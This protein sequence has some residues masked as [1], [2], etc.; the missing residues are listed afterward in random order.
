MPDLHTE[1]DDYTGRPITADAWNGLRAFREAG[2]VSFHH[3]PIPEVRERYIAS[4]KANGLHESQTLRCQD[5]DVDNFRVRVIDPRPE[6][7]RSLATPAVLF[8]HGG[9]WLMGNLDTHH[10]AARRIASLTGFPVIAVDYRLAPEHQY[11]AAVDDCRA[12][13]RWVS[14]AHDVHGLSVTS[15]A[16]MGDSAGGQLTAVLCNEFT[17]DATVAPI[18][19]QVLIYPITDISQDRTENGASYQRV[20][21]GFPMVADTMRWF[22]D[23]YLPE[24]Q[25][26]TVADL[27]PLLHELPDHLPPS[28]VVTVDNDP[29]ADEGAEYAAALVRAG[30]DV[31][32]RHLRGYHHG[33]FTSAGVMTAGETG[34]A[35]IAEFI[36]EHAC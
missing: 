7:K 1:R 3:I 15:L 5:F 14:Q 8:I 20:D 4:C 25:D 6:F 32:Y 18:S 23:T 22:I 9:G 10:S 11:P 30:T 19:S 36:K 35:D 31:T 26:R 2:A 16:I 17:G 29:L 21:G 27:S 33:L 34:L 13:V 24:G 28:Y 12:A